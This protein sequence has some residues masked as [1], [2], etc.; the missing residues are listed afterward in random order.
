M[1]TI[2]DFRELKIEG[3]SLWEEMSGFKLGLFFVRKNEYRLWKRGIK[4][5]VSFATG[6]RAF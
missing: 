6:H 3:V 5:C 4:N 1:R 2:P